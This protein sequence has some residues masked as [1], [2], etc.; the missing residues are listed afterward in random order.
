MLEW[1]L[2]ALGII[3]AIVFDVFV[4]HH[5]YELVIKRNR[6]YVNFNVVFCA[7][8]LHASVV[9]LVA[10]RYALPGYGDRRVWVRALGWPDHCV[11]L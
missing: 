6:F 4:T 8:D 1:L 2:L 11:R 3:I 7:Y 5:W 10:S 9:L